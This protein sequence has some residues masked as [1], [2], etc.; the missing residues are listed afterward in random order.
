MLDE[1]LRPSPVAPDRAPGGGPTP[2]V[3]RARFDV[4]GTSRGLRA[5]LTHPV[6]M[7]IVAVALTLE[8]TGAGA[9][10]DGPLWEGLARVAPVVD[11]ASAPTVIAVDTETIARLGPPPW[12]GETWSVVRAALAKQNIDRIVLADPWPRL[13]RVDATVP[14]GPALL[15][16]PSAVWDGRT[17]PPLPASLATLVSP[18]TGSLALPQDAR[19]IRVPTDGPT[20]GEAPLACAPPARCPSGAT[21]LP[22]PTDVPVVPLVTLLD[23]PTGFLHPGPA[24]VLLGLTDPLFV[25]GVRTGSDAAPRPWVLVD[26]EVVA[27]AHAGRVVRTLPLPAAAL[28]LLALHTLVAS[29]L[30]SRPWPRWM[31]L[32]P[33][34]GAAA[35]AAAWSA[36]SLTAPVATAILAGFAAPA[37]RAVAV[38][39]SAVAAVRRL[40]LLV[41]RAASRAG[42]L[43]RRIATPEELAAVLADT[44]RSHAEACD[45][46]VLL[47]SSGRTRLEVAGAY[48][49]TAAELRDDVLRTTQA[50]VRAAL[51]TWQPV[52]TPRLLPSGREA[53]VLP[54]VQGRR[55]VALWVLA[56][57]AGAP[58]PSLRR[59]HPLARWVA[60]RLALPQD[61][62]SGPMGDILPELV[63]DEALDAMFAGA[64]EERRRWVLAIRALGHPVLVAEPG[65]TVSMTN[66]A[67]DRALERAG[68]PRVRSVRELAYR[69]IGEERVSARMAALATDGQPLVVGWPGAP[70]RVLVIRPITAPLS[71]SDETAL[72]GFLGWIDD[73]RRHDR[74]TL[75][76]DEEPEAFDDVLMPL[77]SEPSPD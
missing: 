3:R 57:R 51:E 42:T 60:D 18:I 69:L 33:L 76:A 32:G 8:V 9:R 77:Q 61:D 2:D 4:A 64:D 25:E 63:D 23:A 54:L 24:G 12:S 15:R 72:L 28:W 43:R 39:A 65:G 29:A 62:A 22:G 41:V 48:G 30:L 7:A 59:L 21:L 66:P 56:A 58:P 31:V 13:V 75:R 70:D 47:V 53:L 11:R 68:L 49:L 10:L 34:V 19:V 74:R 38:S 44:A 16:V 52:R 71:G 1:P 26:A 45:T 17:V 46:A 14:D 35:A 6:A 20:L 55:V 67:M 37:G 50:D 27:A 73:I 5:L 40:G 36:S